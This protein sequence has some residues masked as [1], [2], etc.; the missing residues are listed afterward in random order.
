MNKTAYAVRRWAITGDIKMVSDKIGHS[1][2]GYKLNSIDQLNQ[3][4]GHTPFDRGEV[5][6]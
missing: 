5:C 3:S 4:E 2:V 1:S 6:Y